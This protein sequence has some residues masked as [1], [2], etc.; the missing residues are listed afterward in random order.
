MSLPGPSGAAGGEDKLS[1]LPGGPGEGSSSCSTAVETLRSTEARRGKMGT[2][3]SG[4]PIITTVAPW[5]IQPAR[6]EARTNSQRRTMAPCTSFPRPGNTETGSRVEGSD[7][8]RG[9]IHEAAKKEATDIDDLTSR[10]ESIGAPPPTAFLNECPGLSTKDSQLEVK[11]M[12]YGELFKECR[13][14]N[15]QIVVPV[16]QRL[17]CWPPELATAFWRDAVLGK[18]GSAAKVRG[19][20]SVGR[21]LFR[22]VATKDVPS[23][24]PR[25]GSGDGGD[26]QT[27]WG[28]RLASGEKKENSTNTNAL[29]CLDGQQR[30]TTAVLAIAAIRDVAVFRVNELKRATDETDVPRI[31]EP[32]ERATDETDVSPFPDLLTGLTAVIERANEAL[33]LRDDDGEPNVRVP[34]GF[35][36]SDTHVRLS[37]TRPAKGMVL[38]DADWGAQSYVT[39]AARKTFDTFFYPS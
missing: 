38:P 9:V 25:G 2:P 35:P 32:T 36:K 27:R 14:E 17:Y 24:I 16:F 23:S 33:Y 34:H 12:T 29:L 3:G 4:K 1:A 37:R 13:K 6:R 5:A 19:G 10:R 8:R 31:K 20:H 18:G 21:C 30:L 15:A 39:H 22:R 11:T 7:E 26:G 28:A